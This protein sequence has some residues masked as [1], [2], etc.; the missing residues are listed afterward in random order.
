MKACFIKDRRWSLTLVSEGQGKVEAYVQDG[1]PLRNRAG[2]GLA[3]SHP[4]PPV[5]SQQP[6]K[7][8][9]SSRKFGC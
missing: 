7:H 5:R 4:E 3:E 6:I 8:L 9:L 1:V 2:P